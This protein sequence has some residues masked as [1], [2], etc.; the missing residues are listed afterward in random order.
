MEES[1]VPRTNAAVSLLQARA[2]IDFP[3][4]RAAFSVGKWPDQ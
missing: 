1:W 4:D 2:Q 3:P